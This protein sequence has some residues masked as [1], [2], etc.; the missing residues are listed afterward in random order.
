MTTIDPMGLVAEVFVI[1]LIVLLVITVAL[2]V[3]LV[4]YAIMLTSQIRK[5]ATSVGKARS[6]VGGAIVRKLKAAAL[7][8]VIDFTK[9]VIAKRKKITHHEE[10]DNGPK[11]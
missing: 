11:E 5:I 7:L 10:V 4:V 2:V 1:L 3:A 6:S 8:L 9:R